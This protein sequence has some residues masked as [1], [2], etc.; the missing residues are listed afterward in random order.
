MVLLRYIVRIQKKIDFHK[1]FS[2]QTILHLHL[3]RQVS[4]NL[5]CQFCFLHILKIQRNSSSNNPKILFNKSQTIKT[6]HTIDKKKTF[7]NQG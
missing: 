4:V 6:Y 3:S 2:F 1:N 5:E 7:I